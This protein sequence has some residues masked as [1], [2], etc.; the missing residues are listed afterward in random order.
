MNDTALR[1]LVTSAVALDQEIEAKK[2][3][4]SALEKQLKAEAKTRTDEQTKTEGGG[5]SWTFASA[6]GAAIIRVTQEG[7]K[8]KG[9]IDDEVAVGA[10]KKIAGGIFDRLFTPVLVYKPVASFREEAKA[11]LGAK[12]AAFVKLV[13]GKGSTKVAYE[14]REKAEA[15]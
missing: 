11:L 9:R 8:L 13:S 6:D 4:L 7:K 5:W 14:T 2:A 3:E 15:A 1:K 12:A 10:L